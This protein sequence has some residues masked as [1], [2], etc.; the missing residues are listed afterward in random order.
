M[1]RSLEHV[2]S[3]LRPL[4]MLL[5]IGCWVGQSD[6]GE[7]LPASR[8]VSADSAVS[9][10]EKRA[11]SP[12]NDGP[13]RF[14]EHVQPIL[15]ARC[16]RCHDQQ[17]RKAELVLD[18]PEGI[19]Q[20][21]ESGPVFVAGKPDESRLVELVESGE[22]PPE[23]E[24]RLTKEEIALIREWVSSG[25]KFEATSPA[26]T[27]HQ[28]DVIPILLL[29]CAP[30]HGRQTQEGELDLRTKAG[31]LE[32]GKSGPAIVP[33]NSEAS[34]LVQ[35]IRRG[36][37]PPKAL[38]AAHSV[39]PV[40]QVELAK[41][42]KWI[43]AGAPEIDIQPDIATTQPDPL[44]SDEDRNFWS[45][46]PPRATRPP[47]SETAAEHPVDAFV[48]ARLQALG[49]SFSS[50]ADR[51]TLIRRAY[52]D[53]SGLPPEPADVEAF[54]EDTGPDA[55]EK[56]LD[57][58]LASPHYGERWGQY[59]L[60]LAGYSDSEGVQ[61]SDPIRP[62][63]YRYRD[64]VIEAWNSDK[65]Y[66]R[67]L[68]EQL[69]GDELADYEAAETLTDELYNNLVAT[70]FL[71]MTSDGTFSG[72]TG[73]VPNR[74]DVIDDQVRVLSSAVLGLTIRCARCH[75]HKFDP[76]PQRDYYRLLAVFKG[77]M[78]EHD[79]LRPIEQ[80]KVGVL[81]NLP[82]AR[83]AERREWEEREKRRKG[84][85]ER[86]R[87]ELAKADAEQK[88]RLEAAIGKLESQAEPA[89][90]I[91]ALWDRGEPSPTYILRR[92]DYLQPT[93]L[94]GPG[95]PSVLTNGR[96]PF[97]ATQ[98]WPGATKTG[99]RLELA[100]WLI[101]PD[102]P[103]TARVMVNRIWKH[104]FGRGIVETLD[105]LGRAGA[106]PSHPELLDWLAVEFAQEGWEVKRMHRLLMTSAAYCQTSAVEEAAGRLDPDN[107]WWSRKPL[108]RRD[109]ESL[110]DALLAVAGRLD[111]SRFGPPDG[112]EARADGLITPV[113]RAGGFRR[114]IYVL[115]RRTQ[116]V[117]L[118]DSF[119][120]PGMSPNC[121]DRTI[122]TVAPQALHLMNNRLVRDL[123][124][125]MSARVQADAGSDMAAQVER[126]CWIT[127]GRPPNDTERRAGES[128]LSRLRSEWLAHPRDDNPAAPAS[129]TV[130][131]ASAGEPGSAAL[132]ELNSAAAGDREWVAHRQ[133]LENFCHALM[134]SAA[135]LYID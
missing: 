29:R 43:D 73:F 82:L 60:D 53:L 65:P 27:L 132:A 7:Q 22:M 109:A 63:A 87:G 88:K 101:R 25:A 69:A 24:P 10:P 62:H 75:S 41:L 108:E 119:D 31:M 38:L 105:D 51:M 126:A 23:G 124:R 92:G 129:E 48:L 91:R 56:L 20:G 97:S 18:Q 19:Q 30:C 120:R 84:D 50:P 81:R 104:H 67:F 8:A 99:N 80:S 115:K 95:V 102:H 13:V 47:L 125:A 89:P 36:E 57:R 116:P 107:R 16:Y 28:H 78:D 1:P 9:E 130:S 135:F 114:S 4:W 121:V 49:L 2:N 52:F 86:L 77:A 106:R 6:G 123:A 35:R 70:G 55:Y 34:L 17:S 111:R 40:E 46:Q 85:I 64:Y 3:R 72:I 133:A 33:G 90:A 122:S 128:L 37:M 68:L 45:F 112:I 58:L 21:G 54:L 100:R 39:K 98:P 134:N 94:V 79:W 117:T 15:A 14:V 61:D 71:R 5:W 59:W 42:E 12:P 11:D 118:L 131:A 74:L 103:L 66:D 110:H 127:W 93:R 32:G 44:V 26:A 76:L 83:P 96:T 113:S